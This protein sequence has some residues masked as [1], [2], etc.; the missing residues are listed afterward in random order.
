MPD[1]RVRYDRVLALAEYRR[2]RVTTNTGP[3][4]ASYTRHLRRSPSRS[5]PSPAMRSAMRCRRFGR[6]RCGV[7]GLILPM[8]VVVIDLV[9]GILYES[10]AQPLVILSGLRAVGFG[11]LLT[12]NLF[13]S[14][15]PLYCLYAFVGIT[16]LVGRREERHHDGRLRPGS[17]AEEEGG[18]ARRFAKRVSSASGR[19]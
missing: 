8:A 16:M 18:R 11:A 13:T 19:S 2:A 3:L 10:V 7:D 5:I 14:E 17:R 6:C 1:R 12:L 4:S 9:L 15:V